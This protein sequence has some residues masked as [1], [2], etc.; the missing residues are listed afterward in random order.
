ML[1]YFQVNYLGKGVSVFCY[2]RKKEALKTFL[3]SLELKKNNYKASLINL[4]GILH[5]T[6]KVEKTEKQWLQ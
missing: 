6:V 1:A 3:L 4:I 5:S 2:L